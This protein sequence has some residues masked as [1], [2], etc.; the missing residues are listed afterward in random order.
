M[1]E[2]DHL[3]EFFEKVKDIYDYIIIDT[4]PV[5]LVSDTLHI[6]KYADM[7]VYVV[8]QNYSQ[9]KFLDYLNEISRTTNFP[10]LG[11][12]MNDVKIK[13]SRYGYGN[14]NYG[15]GSG[16]YNDIESDENMINKVMDKFKK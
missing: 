9:K 6:M 4:P 7:C 16:Y 15:Y 10:N 3:K 8:R 13:R 1:L 11:I 5:G 2:T 14:Y 12:V